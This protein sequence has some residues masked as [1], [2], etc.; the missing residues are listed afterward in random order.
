MVILNKT[1]F[2]K[3][4]AEDF[5]AKEAKYNSWRRDY[6]RCL[7]EDRNLNASDSVDAHI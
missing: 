4:Q 6:T 7:Y 2:D 5:I 1:V 3:M